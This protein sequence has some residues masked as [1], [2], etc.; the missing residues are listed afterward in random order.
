MRVL[1]KPHVSQFAEKDES[2]I[3]RVVE[4][5]FRELPKLGVELLEPGARNY[6]LVAVHAGMAEGADVAHCHGLYWTADYNAHPWEWRSNAAVVASL[7]AALAISVPSRWVAESLQREMRVDPTVIGHGIDFDDWQQPGEYRGWVLWNKNRV[8]DVCDPDP[9]RWLALAHPDQAFL[10]TY[11]PDNPPG[12]VRACGLRPH[13]EMRELLKASSVYLATT[14][15]TFGIGTLEAMA[16]GVPVLGFANGGNLELVKHGVNGY[17]AR[18]GDKDDL[19]EGLSYCLTHRKTLGDNGREMARAHTWA[20][21]ARQVLAL[22]EFA[23]AARQETASVSVIIPSYKYAEKVGRAI[24]SVLAQNW[25][26]LEAVIV[27]DDGSPDDGATARAVEAF[28][29]PRVRYI[30]QENRGVAHAR[31]RGIA[32]ARTKYICCLDADDAIEPTFLRECV[33]VLE[34]DRTLGIAYTGLRWIKPDGSQG[35]S[36]WPGDWNYDAQLRRQNQVPT[37]CV[38]R[39]EMWARLGGFRQRYAPKGAGAEDAEFWTRSGAYGWGARRATAEP[40]FVYSWLSGGVTGSTDYKEVDWLRW[41]PWVVDNQHPIAS[42]ATPKRMSHAARQYDEPLVSVIIPVGPGHEGLLV[43]AVDS[44]EAQSFRKWEA[45][46]VVDGAMDEEDLKPWRKAYPYV[47]WLVHNGKRLGAGAARNLGRTRARAP[48]LLFLDA[49]DYLHPDALSDMLQG[50]AASGAIVYS[51]YVGRA[52]VD[53]PT[54]LARELQERMYQWEGGEAFI[55]YRAAEYEP[56]RA[57]RQPED[58]PPYLWAN[59]TCLV[60]S[61]WHDGIGGFDESLVSWEDVDYHWRMARAGRCYV[62]LEKEL[63]CYRF[64]TGTRRETGLQDWPALVEYLRKKYKE[65]QTVGC[66]CAGQKTIQPPP[67]AA[68]A[69]TAAPANGKEAAMADEQ[70]VMAKYVHPNQGVHGVIGVATRTNYGYRGGGETF[71]VH[72]D[73]VA[74]QPHL[75]QPLEIVPVA[76]APAA[77]PPEPVKPVEP[78]VVLAET[79]AET[80]EAAATTNDDI[81]WAKPPEAKPRRRSR[82]EA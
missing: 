56:E 42:Q 8:G 38:F 29:D 67:A 55:G 11:L 40:L 63:L 4:A 14:K 45:I 54:K 76:T 22:Y 27:V 37:C 28:K 62:R 77:P 32:E 21:A 52:H 47:R 41:H 53:D 73:D 61:A 68:W 18:P 57:Q 44:L 69:E 12:N 50:W 35:V 82:K 33:Q 66:N 58:W 79:A 25:P 16:A 10:T 17:L 46:V 23:G 6:D 39:R 48:F 13:D 15:E 70:Y 81:A 78:P 51:D 7:R 65:I 30:R 1:M 31:N 19:A 64:Y 36:Q 71:L 34:Q 43:D 74:A 9:I 72:R 75:F 20:R 5:Y 3:R 59:V 49:D 26:L 24:E 80:T 2:G 60:P